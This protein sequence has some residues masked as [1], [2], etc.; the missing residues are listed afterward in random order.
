MAHVII[1]KKKAYPD[2]MAGGGG[3]GAEVIDY[4]YAQFTEGGKITLP[5]TLNADYKISVTFQAPTYKNDNSVIGNTNGA[6]Y[7]H[8]TIYSNRYYSSGGSGEVNFAGDVYAK[9]TFVTNNNGHNTL[10]GTDVTNYTPTTNSGINLVLAGRQSSG[11]NYRGK[12]Y[13]YII[14]SISTGEE[15]IHLKPAKIQVSGVTLKQ[16]LLDTVSGDMYETSGMSLGNDS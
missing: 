2:G 4:D 10:D 6:S 3:G 8:L 11:Q 1:Y 5:F 9:H 16:G 12:I 13:E 15:L 7:S 14:E